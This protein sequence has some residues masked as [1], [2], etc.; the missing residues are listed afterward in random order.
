MIIDRQKILYEH[1]DRI[2]NKFR[3]DKQ[4]W[5]ELKDSKIFPSEYID[6]I[7]V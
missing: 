1:L 6:Y 7:Q 2:V 4:F 3:L 5:F